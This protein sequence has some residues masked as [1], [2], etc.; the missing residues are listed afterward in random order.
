MFDAVVL[1]LQ[2]RGEAAEA[3]IKKSATKLV[4]GGLFVL[5]TVDKIPKLN[6]LSLV[7][8]ESDAYPHIY[9][10]T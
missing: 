4:K 7:S 3:A 1:D 5:A 6:G 2:F 8:E 9:R 10:N